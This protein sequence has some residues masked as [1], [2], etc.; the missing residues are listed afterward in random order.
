MLLLISKQKNYLAAL[1]ADYSH[2]PFFSMSV[3]EAKSDPEY[4]MA[5]SFK[6]FIW[7]NFEL[8]LFLKAK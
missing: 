2:I 8:I 4:V 5:I 6:A 3:P 7:K 1:S